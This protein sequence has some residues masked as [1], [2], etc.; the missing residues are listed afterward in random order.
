MAGNILGKSLACQNKRKNA[1]L[2]LSPEPTAFQTT[3]LTYFPG[4]KHKRKAISWEKER[5]LQKC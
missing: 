5:S 4:W 1:Y 3:F 2:K